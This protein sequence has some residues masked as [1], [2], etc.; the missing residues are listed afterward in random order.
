MRVSV[1][2][3]NEKK[4]QHWVARAYLMAWTTKSDVAQNPF[5]WVWSK[6]GQ[7]RK[8]RGPENVFKSNDLYTFRNTDGSRNLA[9]EDMFAEI[10]NRFLPVRQRLED[11]MY[12]DAEGRQAIETFLAAQTVRTPFFRDHW[13]KQM[14][15]IVEQIDRI[16]E[17]AK[18]ATIEEK[19]RAASINVTP[20]GESIPPEYIR[21]TR[22]YP[23]QLVSP[24][25]IETTVEIL[26]RMRMTIFFTDDSQGWI[27]SDAPATKYD[28]ESY[29]YPPFHRSP[30]LLMKTVEIAMPLSPRFMV[31][32]THNHEMPQFGIVRENFL[33]EFNRR[34]R[35]MAKHAFI[36]KLPE[37][38]PYWF[39]EFPLPEDSWEAKH[40][41]KEM[42]REPD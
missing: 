9:L 42:V 8:A 33:N 11:R 36:T 13:Q 41:Y 37:C 5:V 12:P 3:P 20:R 27:T 22:D 19:K 30:G 10:E 16:E 18:T 17:W 28:P 6:D 31:M 21:A 32:F 7:S 23:F 1:S 25:M 35:F 2:K 14:G 39:Q 15:Q 4:R 29:K 24:M 34:T 40:G 38:N 26:S